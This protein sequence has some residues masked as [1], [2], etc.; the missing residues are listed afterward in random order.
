MKILGKFDNNSKDQYSRRSAG[1]RRIEKC[2]YKTIQKDNY[3]EI[4]KIW[5]NELIV[6]KH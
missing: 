2:A 1:E 6:F 3:K 4:T 5:T